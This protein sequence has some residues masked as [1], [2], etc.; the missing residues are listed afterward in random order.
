MR[1]AVL[2]LCAASFSPAFA[3]VY[4]GETAS[5][6]DSAGAYA[7]VGAVMNEGESWQ[8]ARVHVSAGGQ[9]GTA[10][11]PPVA[12]GSEMP[13]KVRLAV[14]PGAGPPSVS[15]EHEAADPPA[16]RA[17]VMY[18]GTLVVHQDGRQ[19]GRVVNTGAEPLRGVRVYALAHAADGRVLD[20]AQARVSEALPG[21]PIT[22]E[23]FADPAVSADSYSC[24]AVGEP[25]VVEY[26]ADR[27]G[28]PYRFRYDSAAWLAYAR[29]D[30]GRTMS[31]TAKNSF[32]FEA[33]ANIE[34]PVLSGAEKFSVTLDGAPVESQQSRGQMGNWHLVFS[35][36]PF[37]DGELEITGFQDEAGGAW[38]PYLAVPAA[39][40]AGLAWYR[41]RAPS[42]GRAR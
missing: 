6:T 13:F 30:D 37:S 9:S 20:A 21:E 39:A 2:A 3:S 36:P 22:F 28:E 4:V 26:A 32:P 7:V 40:A 41:L 18:D 33:L 38:Y 23:M 31:M 34:L 35:M 15:L 27:M 29:F 24:F 42:R 14:P 10:H 19:S 16:A 11:L 17:R 1:A 5:Y 25:T 12:P 8:A